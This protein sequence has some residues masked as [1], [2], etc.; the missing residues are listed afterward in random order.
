MA[1]RTIFDLPREIHQLILEF[2]EPLDLLHLRAVCQSF[3]ELIPPPTIQQLLQ[4]EVSD[5]GYTKDIYTCRDCMRLRPRARFADKMVKKKKSKVSS[6]AGKRFCVD[7]GTNPNLL[8]ETARYTRGCHV[9]ILG[10]HHVV[11]Y[12]CGRFG[13]AAG[14]RGVY[15][16][17]C[18]DCQL[19]DRF[20]DRWDDEHKER[21]KEIREGAERVRRRVTGRATWRSDYEHRADYINT[22]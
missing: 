12:C 21:R 17:E 16:D 6:D 18:R 13:P 9:V 5:F 14:E 11:C 4:V 22:A 8:P 15:M 19:Q 20:L 2:A 1:K 3:R 7:C 10:E